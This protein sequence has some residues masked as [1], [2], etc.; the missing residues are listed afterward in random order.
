MRRLGRALHGRSATDGPMLSPLWLL[1]WWR[2]FGAIGKRRLA[3]GAIHD[4]E[5]LVGLA[6]L[7]ARTHRYMPGIPFR[8]LELLGTG[9]PE[10]DEVCSEYLGVLAERGAEQVVARAFVEALGAG[11]FGAWD[12]LV[13]GPMD[14]DNPVASAL[15][16]E[17]ARAG[18][19]T[20]LAPAGPAYYIELPRTFAD[21][22]AHLS[23]S[24]RYLLTRSKRDFEKWAD[25]TAV[26]HVARSPA[27]LEEGKRALV[28]LH[29]ERWGRGGAFGSPRFRDF[30]DQVMAGL[31]ARGALDLLWLTV[32]GEPVAAAYDI[33]WAGRVYYYQ[34]GRRLDVP[35]NIRPGIV[36]HAYAV[37]RAIAAGLREYD[38]FAG[39]YRYK[40]ELATACRSVVRLRAVREPGG[41]RERAR[42]LAEEA[43]SVARA[44]KRAVRGGPPALTPPSTEEAPAAVLHGDLNMLRCFAG[45]DVRTVVLSSDPDAPSF[46]SRHCGQRR[47]LPDPA[48]EPEAAL[49]ALRE[50]GKLIPGKPVLFYGDDAMLLLVSRHREELR[51]RFRFALPE[52]AQV[53]ALVDKKRFA[54]LAEELAL[55]VPRTVVSS[56]A[57]SAAEI[58]AL[59]PLPVI[60]KPFCH[61][62]WRTSQAVRGLGEGPV[63]ALYAGDLGALARMLDR[64]ASFTTEFVVQEYIPGGEDQV[65]SFH[66]Y[67]DAGR[68]SLGHYVGRKI[69][70]YPRR[71][72]VSTY[73][74][75]VDAPD[76]GAPR[77]RRRR[78]ARP[79]RAW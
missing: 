16:A 53:E 38:F 10:A 22:T 5:R 48:A 20:E 59:L 40:R 3:V 34:S 43:R 49:G 74:E 50:L 37:E 39:A 55:P 41:V 14:R 4:G 70:T 54:A 24:S 42:L 23:P 33:V 52:A 78:A 64:I 9:E 15:T 8:R 44:V 26:L 47:L 77:L 2:V 6:P 18:A 17:L 7:V 76:L 45:A 32:R 46:F 73:L 25:G 60:L 1:A 29:G 35:R 11:A 19:G 27:D 65:Y 57:A 75:L 66:A 12:E 13:L 69:R 51:A 31:L 72:G 61:L 30:H 68:K 56:G 71:A 79:R 36:L 62:G 58:A 67:L 63:K 28:A 21:Y